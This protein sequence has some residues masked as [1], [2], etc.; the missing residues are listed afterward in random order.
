[1]QSAADFFTTNAT[2][3]QNPPQVDVDIILDPYV[4]NIFPQSLLPTAAY[5][6]VLA[7][8][9]FFVSDKLWRVASPPAPTVKGHI[10]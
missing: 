5:I 3:M 4:A 8:I 6:L 2:L 9:A 7:V 1:M 10:D